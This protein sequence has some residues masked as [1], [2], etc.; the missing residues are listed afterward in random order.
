MSTEAWKALADDRTRTGEP[1]PLEPDGPFDDMWELLTVEQQQAVASGRITLEELVEHITASHDA[2]L[3]PR[4]AAAPVSPKYHFL[5]LC[6]P[7]ARKAATDAYRETVAELEAQREANR[8]KKLV[9]RRRDE[10]DP[11]RQRRPGPNSKRA[12]DYGMSSMIASDE[13]LPLAFCLDCGATIRQ[14]D[15]DQTRCARCE[16]QCEERREARGSGSR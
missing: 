11:G 4:C 16:E 15:A 12:A 10:L 3:C 6:V 2:E 1:L 5:G 8:W 7:C 14:H 9:Q 13:P